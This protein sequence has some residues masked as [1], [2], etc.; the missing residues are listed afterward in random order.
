M[1]ALVLVLGGYVFGLAWSMQHLSYDVWG[2]IALIPVLIAVSVP[3]ATR[4]ARREGDA[5]M[6]RLIIAAL[7]LKLLGSLVRY[8]VAFGVYAGSADA[9]GYHEAGRRLAPLYRGGHFAAQIDGPGGGTRFLKMLTGLVYA[10]IGPSQ[11]GGF[12][13]FSW[14]GFWGLYLFYRA[15][16]IGVP[17]GDARRYA[18]LVF[19]LPSMLFWPSSIGKEAVITLTLG[20]TAYGAASLYARR[21]GALL[22]AALGVAGTA[23]VRSHVALVV[24]GALFAGYL[25]RRSRGVSTYAPLAKAAGLAVLV[26]AS[27]V[28][29]GRFKEDL[30]LTTLDAKSVEHVLDKNQ[31]NTSE[32]GSKFV[33]SRGGSVAGIP[34]SLLT[35][36]FRPWLFEAS[37][38]QNLIASVEGTV[39]LVLFAKSWRRLRTV[40]RQIRRCPYVAMVL[41]YSLLFAFAFSTFS[42]FGIIARQRVQLFPFVLVLLALPIPTGERAAL[43]ADGPVA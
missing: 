16:R 11:L 19:F 15:F 30:G 36:L 38:A 12:L 34:Q 25:F 4:A 26:A 14:L 23:M 5:R 20:M 40:P 17:H 35:I 27:V 22:V 18:V 37:N 43:V 33:T 41:A 8:A 42:N 9:A 28:M 29:L 10:A 31:R 6:R 32:G 7:V 2:A 24:F 1:S 39:L 21:R 13:F 3:L